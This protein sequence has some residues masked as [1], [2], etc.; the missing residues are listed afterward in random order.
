MEIEVAKMTKFMGHKNENFGSN[1]M[2]SFM[3]QFPPQGP[4]SYV[5]RIVEEIGSHDVRQWT[6]SEAL[7]SRQPY[8]IDL[9]DAD[10]WRAIAIGLLALSIARPLLRLGGI[11]VVCLLVLWLL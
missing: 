8:E 9:L 2:G 10:A 6:G 11:V 1:L 4:L 7:Q 5:A 3:E